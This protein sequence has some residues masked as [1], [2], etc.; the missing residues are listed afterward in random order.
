MNQMM[1]RDVDP[2]Q[3]CKHPPQARSSGPSRPSLAE[4]LADPRSAFWHPA[5]VVAHPLL[6][7][8]EKRTILISWARDEITLEH[9]AGGVLPE[10]KPAL[11]ID[12]VVEALREI[13]PHAAAEYH[14]VANGTR[15][16]APKRR[17]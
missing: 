10:L 2:I 5:E 6:S 8:E 16:R 17:E 12:A 4:M 3:S 13:D 1:V 11:Q 14:A 7:Q 15:A 9:M